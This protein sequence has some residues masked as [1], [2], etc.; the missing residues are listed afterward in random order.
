MFFLTLYNNANVYKMFDLLIKVVKV[1]SYHNGGLSFSNLYADSE[2]HLLN[3]S[4]I[5]SRK[6][7]E[8][9]SFSKPVYL[10]IYRK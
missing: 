7:W 10:L 2:N 1:V 5:L 9:F 3:V 6:T 8:H 4:D